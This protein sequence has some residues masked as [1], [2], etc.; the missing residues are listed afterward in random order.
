MT[1]HRTSLSVRGLL[2]AAALATSGAVAFG[3]S[4]AVA[5]VAAGS[6]ICFDS[7]APA[8]AGVVLNGT[9][10]RPLANGF[11]NFFPNNPNVDPTLNSSVNFEPSA[12][13]ANSIVSPVGPDGKIC[14]YSS[15]P[16]DVI[17]DVAG[18][19]D[20]LEL[21]VFGFGTP[22]AG[23]AIRVLDSRQDEFKFQPG[24]TLCFQ[25]FDNPEQG[26]A[27]FLNLTAV[28][29]E[30]TGFLNVYPNGSAGAPDANS[31]IN[32]V[33]GRNIANATTVTAGVNGEIC[34]YAS[35]VTDVIMDVVAGVDSTVFRPAR[36]DNSAER[37]LDTR[38]GAPLAAGGTTCLATSAA[39][40]E[41]VVINATAIRSTGIGYLNIYPDGAAAPAA[42]SIINFRTG[43]NIANGTIVPVGA[44][45]RVCIYA[46][47]GTDVAIDLIGFLTAGTFIPISADGSA[48]RVLDTRS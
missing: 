15:A 22:E 2:T 23:E 34:V 32:F 36:A 18:F 46:S 44:G 3:A 25:P 11:L 14:V 7:G 13:I 48:D 5:G 27:I 31:A 39:A 12:N 24:E 9:A 47:L 45:G 1:Q 19:I 4:P 42:N 6:T 28:A 40:G 29:P 35:N 8:G 10:A 26:Q 16:T 38:S 33:A 21:L 37:I 20:P 43:A 17:A 30:G 41:A